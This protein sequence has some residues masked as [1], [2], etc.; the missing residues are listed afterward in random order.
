MNAD[1]S[2]RDSNSSLRV[3]MHGFISFELIH[4]MLFVLTDLNCSLLVFM[5]IMLVS[6]S[7]PEVQKPP[8]VPRHQD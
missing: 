1:L 8:F 7:R 5:H 2:D 3:F 6:E 4:M